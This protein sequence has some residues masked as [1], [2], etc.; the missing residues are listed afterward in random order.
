MPAD[1]AVLRAAAP[2]Q[3]NASADLQTM[4][5]AAGET[6]HVPLKIICTVYGCAILAC[7]S[8]RPELAH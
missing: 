3:T 5:N 1:Y 4:T 2:K 7:V 8:V 6:K